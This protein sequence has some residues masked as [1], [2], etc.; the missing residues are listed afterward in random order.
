MPGKP[1]FEGDPSLPGTGSKVNIRG[2]ESGPFKR[3]EENETLRDQK[4]NPI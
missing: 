4:G 1:Y 2:V 3:T